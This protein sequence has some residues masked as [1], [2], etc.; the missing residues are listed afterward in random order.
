MR[1]PTE[2]V[3]RQL[4]DEPAGVPSIHREHVVSCQE[5]ARGLAAIRE[6]ADLVH[7]ALAT[8][9][10][11]NLDADAAWRRLS[12]ATA[13]AGRIRSVAPRAGRFRAALR[14]PVVAGVAV[15]AIVTGASTVAANDWLPIFRTERVAPL[16]ISPAD[17]NALPDL[18][19][20]G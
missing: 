16:S 6:D 4:L 5:C 11:D 2:G 12:A 1:H 3:L 9:G 15:A 10:A 13:T 14:R 7:A 19:A 17:L 8:E 20:Y 18:R